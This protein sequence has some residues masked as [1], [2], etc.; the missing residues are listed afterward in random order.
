MRY[1]SIGEYFYRLSNRCLAL[2]LF[3]VIL[4]WV[5]YLVNQYFFSGLPWLQ[6]SPEIIREFVGAITILIV[7]SYGLLYVFI[8]KRL[9][10]IKPEPSLGLRMKHYIKIVFT[11]FRSFS[12]MVLL[13]GVGIFLTNDL[14]LL[15]PLPIPI[16]LFLTH[17]PTHKRMTFDLKLKP[18]EQEVLKNKSLG[19]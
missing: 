12:L 17:W 6:F 1:N 19:V 13:I 10:E 4:I 7:L 5:A 15:F 16:V 18:E 2:A 11:R 14:N 9:K 8:K 3:P